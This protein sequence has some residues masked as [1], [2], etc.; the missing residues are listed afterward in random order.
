MVGTFMYLTASSPDLTFAYPKDYSIALT[1]YADADHAGWQDTRRSTFGSIQLLG[2]RLVSW[3]SKRKKSDVIS[4]T[5]AEYIA[6]SGCCAQVLW[7]RSHIIDYGLGFNKIPMYCDNKSVLRCILVNSGTISK[8]CRGKYGIDEIANGKNGY[9][10]FKFKDEVGMNVV[11]EK[12]WM[13]KN[14]PFTKRISALASSLGKP[15]VMDWMTANMCHKGIGNLS[16]ARVLVE[17]DAA[18][19]LKN[20]IEIHYV[21]KN[22]KIKGSKKVQVVYD[23]KLPVCSHCKVFG[24]ENKKCKNGG[25]D[26]NDNAEKHY[27]NAENRYQQNRN[28]KF[29]TQ[30]RKRVQRNKYNRNGN[31][32][33][34][35]LQ[36]QKQANE[37]W[38][39]DRKKKNEEEN[40][41]G[42]EY[43]IVKNNKWKVKEK[44]VEDIR[45]NADKYSVL[46]TLPKDNDQELRTLK[47]RM[48][49]DKFLN[50]KL[51]PTLRESI[52]WSK[53]TIYYFKRNWDEMENEENEME[54]VMEVNNG[55]TK[56]T[57]DNE[58]SANDGIDRRS[59]WKELIKEKR[60]VNGKPWCI[61]GDMNVTLKCLNNIEIEDICKTGLHFTWTKNLQ[62]TK[63]GDMTGILK[64]LDIVMTNEEF[65]KK[66]ANAHAKFLPCIISDHTPSFLCI[67]TSV[68]KKAKAFRFSNYLTDKQEFLHIVKDK[69]S[70]D[71]HGLENLR[72]QLQ[73][74]QTD[75]D[76]DPHTHILR[77]TKA[78]LVKEFYEVKEDEEKF[79]FQQAKIKW[80]SNGDKNNSYFH[81]VLKGRNNRSKILSLKDKNGFNY[82]N[83]Q[84]PHLFLKHFEN[85]LRKAQLVQDIEDCS[86]LFQRRVSEEVALNMIVDV[87]DIE[88]KNAIFDIED[89]KAPGRLVSNNQ[90]AFITGRQIQDNIMLTRKLMKG[91]KR[92]GGPKRVAFKIDLQK[93]AST[94]GFTINTIEKDSKFQYHF[95]CK[96]LKLVNVCFADDLLVMFHGDTSSVEVINR[97]LDEFS[98]SSGLLPNSSKST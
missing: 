79:L 85:F 26:T 3:S 60:Y 41:K 14:K 56:I 39:M 46:N 48:V 6:L 44:V 19:E 86:T 77:N 59:L 55:I 18:K 5:E 10:M 61:A 97:S 94:V 38:R 33:N 51:Q 78:N 16:Y 2:E 83:D 73:K 34:Q 84:I 7:M 25:A 66:F 96:S 92:K 72:G 20:E 13:V 89:T 4:N 12:G 67:P 17:M 58:I 49:V 76:K 50:K 27:D 31:L 93:C 82:K 95:G 68:K 22:K 52:T 91:N 32:N 57:K 53:D 64:K 24:H 21:N 29:V 81:K 28:N 88:I 40:T 54:D 11:I 63:D 23:W 80:L 36:N 45:N 90:S 62:K 74:V 47:E 37:A 71:I 75:I 69:W 35:N 42:K 70:A 30:R 87:S 1:A 98:A 9:Y 15:V 43:H 65:I 8:E